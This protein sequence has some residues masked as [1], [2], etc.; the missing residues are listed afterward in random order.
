VD[1]I[2]KCGAGQIQAYEFKFGTGAQ[3]RGVTV[4]QSYSVDVQLINQENYLDF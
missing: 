1:F 4:L 3:G 2:E